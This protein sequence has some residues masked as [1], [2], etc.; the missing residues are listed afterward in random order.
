M[1]SEQDV[2]RTASYSD[3]IIAGAIV[4][5]AVYTGAVDIGRVLEKLSCS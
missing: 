2:R 4:G 1:S 3:G 5:T